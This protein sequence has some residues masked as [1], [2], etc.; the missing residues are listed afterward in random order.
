MGKGIVRPRYFFEKGEVV[1]E[2]RLFLP[3]MG[4]VIFFGTFFVLLL[5]LFVYGLR[6]H[7]LSTG[8]SLTDSITEFSAPLVIDDGLALL[9]DYLSRFIHQHELNSL[10]QMD[11]DHRQ[12]HIFFAA[13]DLYLNHSAR[14]NPKQHNIFSQM[15]PFLKSLVKEGYF[16]DISG[17]DRRD[18]QTKYYPTN[19]EFSAF[20]ATFLS[21]FLVDQ[22]VDSA[23]I[24]VIAFGSRRESRFENMVKISIYR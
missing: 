21:R 17:Y 2:G 13:D 11:H 18:I 24:R 1:E 5:C 15:V 12:F 19:L 22:G 9:S 14:L 7:F 6:A 23:A 4:K 16:I 10:I 8:D 3:F 20:R